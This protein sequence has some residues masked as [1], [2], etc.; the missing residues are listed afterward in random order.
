MYS[1]LKFNVITAKLWGVSTNICFV[2]L[3]LFYVFLF[4]V[5]TYSIDLL[6]WF[7]VLAYCIGLYWLIVLAYCI[8]LLYCFV[9]LTYCIVLLYWLI[10]LTCIDFLYYLIV[11]TYWIDLLY[12]LILYQVEAVTIHGFVEYM[13]NKWVNKYDF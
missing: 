9:V 10:V 13:G 11:L 12:W 5:L 6:Y 1:K 8:D 7:I 2:C 3:L 4:I